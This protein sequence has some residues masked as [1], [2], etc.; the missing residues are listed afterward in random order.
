MPGPERSY[1]VTGGCGGAGAA[2]V[3]RLD[4]HVVTLDLAYVAHVVGYAAT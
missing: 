3:A 4:G 1:V 2:I